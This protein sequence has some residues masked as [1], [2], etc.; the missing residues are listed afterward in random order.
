MGW[1]MAQSGN[2]WTVITGT[3]YNMTVKGIIVIDGV[4]QTSNQLEIGAFC[5]D[6]CRGS[7][8]AAVFPPTGE[9]TVMLTVVSNVYSGETITFRIYDHT[10]QQELDLQSETTLM[11]EHNT[12]AGSM[13]NWF[14]FVFTTPAPANWDDPNT[15]GG[16]VPGSTSTVT[17]PCDV[18]VG[19]GG[20]ITVTVANLNIPDGNTLTIE[21]G[22]TLVVTGDL[23][24]AD[25]EGLVIEDGAQVINESADVKATYRK[26]ITSYNAKDA[27]GWYTISSPV[28]EM[29]IA[30][31]GF[32]TPEYDLYRYNETRVGGEWENHK[33]NSNTDFTSFETGRGYLYANSN[34]FSPAF[35][36]TLNNADV[37]RHVTYT[38]RPDGLSGFNLIGNPFPHAIYKGAGGA[39]DDAHLASGYYTLTD[40]GAWHVHTYE[41]AIQ[42]GQG[43]LVKTT[44]SAD[45]SIVK[46][47]AVATA[48]TSSSKSAVGRLG[49]TVAG[50]NSE[51]RA[52]AYFGQGIGMEK[53]GNLS[54]QAPS[55]WIRNDGA[56]YA[57]AHVDNACESLDVCFRNRHNAD[58]RLAVDAK[59][60]D[61]GVLQLVDHATGEVVDLKQQPDYGFHANGTEADRRFKLV[62]RVDTGVEEVTEAEP[63]AFISDGQ[64]VVNGEGTLQIFDALGRKVFASDLSSQTSRISLPSSSGV[65]VLRLIGENKVRTQKI[66]V[67]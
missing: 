1:A 31:S 46:S 47:T 32:V 62:F 30:G 22:S 21:A 54:Q 48:E 42:P 36:G 5:G 45:L 51:D 9:Y 20:A 66:V 26:N 3:Q 59:G 55:L 65:Y 27:D 25:E 2:H 58:Y 24:S 12:N 40:E 18:V 60:L 13:G 6:E 4:T 33:D 8:K 19:D 23:T 67:R 7:R 29:S 61:L 49:V 35:T 37:S 39:I 50:V 43:I 57:I 28:S 63:F 41:D 34:T 53:M 56:D 10:T 14:Q 38:D 11:F 52:F 64:L 44:S 17:L 16:S 15:W